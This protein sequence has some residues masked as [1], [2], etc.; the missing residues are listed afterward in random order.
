MCLG[1]ASFTLS[2]LDLLAK[3]RFVKEHW[4]VAVGEGEGIDPLGLALEL[5]LGTDAEEEPEGEPPELGP[6]FETAI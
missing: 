6:L 2:T 1:R 3:V 4:P 5:L